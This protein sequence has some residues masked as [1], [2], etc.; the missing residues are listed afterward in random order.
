MSILNFLKMTESSANTKRK[1]F[2]GGLS[3]NATERSLRDFIS[4]AG[5]IDDSDEAVKI[6]VDFQSGK[7]KGFAF[8]LMESGEGAKKF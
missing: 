6:I 5:K 3:F 2:I 8:V 7:S 1:L 4:Q